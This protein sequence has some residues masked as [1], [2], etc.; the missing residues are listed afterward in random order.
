MAPFARELGVQDVDDLCHRLVEATMIFT[1][2]AV[3]SAG[4]DLPQL[5]LLIQDLLDR[6][7]RT[8]LAGG[9]QKHFAVT[10][11]D[12]SVTCSRASLA[13]TTVN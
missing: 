13:D 10:L 8:R 9:H 12:K 7:L 2:G 11:P 5:R 6:G 3:M 4:E 1:R